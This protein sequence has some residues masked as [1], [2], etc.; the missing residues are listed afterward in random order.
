MDR[1]TDL[2]VQATNDD[3]TCSKACAVKRGYWVD[4]YMHYFCPFSP[5]KSPEISRGYFVRTQAFKAITMSFIQKHC[6][7]CQIVN[8]G[9]GSDTLYFQLRDCNL[10]PEKFFEIDLLHNVK[11]KISVIRNHHL[12]RGETEYSADSEL[13]Q[14]RSSPAS[15]IPQPGI[16]KQ[17]IDHTQSRLFTNIYSLFDFDLRQPAD[18]LTSFICG[19]LPGGGL[20]SFMPTLFL[21]ECVLVYMSSPD[22]LQLIRGICKKF[23]LC[24]FLHYEQVNMNDRFGMIMVENFRTRGCDLPGLSACQSLQEQEKRFIEAGW[25]KAKAWTV[26]EVYEEFSRETRSRVEHVEMLDDL[27][28]SRQ[29][30]DHYCILL[31]TTDDTVCQW[32]S[33]KEPLSLIK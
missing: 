33:L 29:L 19:P 4:H 32:T 24:A 16:T 18:Q 8:L 23:P 30:Y 11:K 17:N 28:I 20:D 26:N 12:L 1:P 9:A 2:V 25:Q 31:A 7:R 21:A 10:V 14:D 15:C 13:L 22:S 27:E 3:A 5:H 6:G